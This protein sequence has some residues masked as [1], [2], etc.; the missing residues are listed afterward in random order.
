M[1]DQRPGAH[2]YVYM[3]VSLAR[4]RMHDRRCR[5]VV[6]HTFRWQVLTRDSTAERRR[7][8]I[9][10]LVAITRAEYSATWFTKVC[11]DSLDIADT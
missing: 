10:V 7:R 4:R 9:P 8:W 11:P 2:T 6:Q 5:H 1:S 3:Y